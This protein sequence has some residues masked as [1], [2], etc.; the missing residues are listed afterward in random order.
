MTRATEWTNQYFRNLLGFDWAVHK[1]GAKLWLLWH[2]R[3]KASPARAPV[4]QLQP[5]LL[6]HIF[7][8]WNLLTRDGDVTLLLCSLQR[9]WAAQAITGSGSRS[10]AK[11]PAA[12]QLL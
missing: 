11:G 2:L 5:V 3:W 10:R 6:L 12:Q 8:V 9:A 4:A 7:H 1:V